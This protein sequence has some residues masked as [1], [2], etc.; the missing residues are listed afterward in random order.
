V[1]PACHFHHPATTREVGEVREEMPT[2][3]GVAVTPVTPALPAED[4]CPEVLRSPRHWSPS[5]PGMER[6]SP[7]CSRPPPVF[8]LRPKKSCLLQ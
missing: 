1:S 2:G 5:L 8:L 7:P 6:W 4:L 3:S